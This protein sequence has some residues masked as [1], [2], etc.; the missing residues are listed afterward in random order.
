M[1]YVP[2]LAIVVFL[3]VAI[4]LFNIPWYKVQLEG[5]FNKLLKLVWRSKG[6]E[7]AV[8]PTPI[9]N[10]APEY[11]RLQEQE[12]EDKKL[13]ETKKIS[14]RFKLVVS[15]MQIISNSK[16]STTVMLKAFDILLH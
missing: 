14:A 9:P 10:W 5:H 1:S 8:H 4:I 3:V 12:Q 7:N 6:N 16:F 2:A 15:T 11:V 13:K